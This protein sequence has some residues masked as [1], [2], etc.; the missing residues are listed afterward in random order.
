MSGGASPLAAFH[1][2]GDR[3]GLDKDNQPRELRPVLF[4]EYHDI[5]SLRHDFPLVLRNRSADGDW[6]KSLSDVIDNVLE[7]TAEAGA[8]GVATRRKLLTLEQ[9]I[10]DLVAE[11]QQGSL[12]LF[13]EAARREITGGAAQPEPGTRA[14]E[15]NQAVLHARK[16]L[17]FDGE[18]AGYDEDL[19]TRLLTCAWRESERVKARRLAARIAVLAQKLADILEADYMHSAQARQAARLKS[20]MGEAGDSVFDFEKMS[21]LLESKPVASPM[22]ASRKKR[23]RSAISILHAQRFVELPRGKDPAAEDTWSFAFDDCR[24]ALA[25]FRER[26][27]DMAALVKAISIAELEIENRYERS[28]HDPFFE[29]F[30]ESQLGPADLGQFPA[31]LVSLKNSDEA[32]QMEILELLR[33]GL[34]FKIVAGVDD[35]LG[36]VSMADGQLSFGIHGQQLAQMALGLDTVFVMQAA[37]SCLYRRSEAVLQGMGTDGPALFSIYSGKGYLDSAA[38]LESRAFPGFVHNPAR[39]PGQSSRFS[40]DGNPQV[41]SDWP[42]HRF[43]FE[44]VG[45]D[46]KSGN[47]AFTLIDFIASDPRFDRHLALAPRSAWSEE[48]VPADEFIDFSDVERAGKVPYILM[49][50]QENILYRAIVNEKLIDAACR[51]RGIWKTLQ[52]RGGINNPH[53]ESALAEAQ[54]AWEEERQALI[55]RCEVTATPEVADVTEAAPAATPKPVSPEPES[56]ASQELQPSSD[57]PWVETVRCTTCNECTQ[58]NDRMFAYDADMRAYIADPDAGSYRDLVEAAET[59]QVAIIHPGKPRNPDEPGLEELM[60][61]AEPFL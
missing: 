24:C 50:D 18:M 46:R 11:G 45:H 42:A 30:D 17:E 16:A 26:L 34:P 57:D 25:T 36:Q 53:A 23:L 2:V 27:A 22:P 9:A 31:Y 49:I 15:L 40:L 41:S 52:E 60:L 35:I 44:E 47:T 5:R 55:A 21:R 6:V 54:K 56:A 1:R 33:S 8:K 10:R 3:S 29:R 13:W 43:T 4:G 39:Y 19:P 7:H 48:M 51:C 59:C 38:A 20:A 28:R 37:A 58:L 12:S 14:D 61:R 32:A